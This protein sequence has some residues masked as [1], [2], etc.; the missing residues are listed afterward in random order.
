M[1]W[2]PFQLKLEIVSQMCEWGEG[3]VKEEAG[4]EEELGFPVANR[5]HDEEEVELDI[6]FSY[7]DSRIESTDGMG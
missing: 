1:E 7:I 6:A 2:V 4:E 5:G 3:R